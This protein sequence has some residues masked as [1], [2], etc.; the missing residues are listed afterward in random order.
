MPKDTRYTHDK[1]PHFVTS[2]KVR[3]RAPPTTSKVAITASSADIGSNLTKFV[4]LERNAFAC[5]SYTLSHMTG[6]RHRLVLRYAVVIS[7]VLLAGASTFYHWMAPEPMHSIQVI[8]WPK[9]AAEHDSDPP[10][11]RIEIKDHP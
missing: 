6:R 10:E 1:S 8:A 7:A 11:L 3:T 5:I 4:Q 2:E 9:D